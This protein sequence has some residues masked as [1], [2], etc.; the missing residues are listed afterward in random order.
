MHEKGII[1]I[2]KAIKKKKIKG[3]DLSCEYYPCHEGLED[4]T[5][6]YCP[7]YP[8]NHNDTG[9]FEKISSRTGQ[10]VWACSSCIFPHKEKNAKQ[11]LNGLIKLGADFNL[12]SKK[13]L[14][15][16]YSKVLNQIGE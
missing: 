9:G 5:F 13:K 2:N 16:L 15:K 1:L 10:P 6:C 3:I 12:I 14:K 11:I 8:C 4:C 7:F